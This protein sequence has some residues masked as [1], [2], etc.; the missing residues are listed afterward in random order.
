M[1][2]SMTGYAAVTRDLPLGTLNLELR[3]V[4]HR[5]L[6]VS[7][8]APEE[9][10]AFEPAMREQLGAKLT[11]GKLECRIGFNRAPTA[12]SVLE[13]NAAM[14]ARL[15]QLN[16]QVRHSLPD[17]ASLSVADVLR[18]PGMFG[19]DTLPLDELREACLSLLRQ[20]L[21]EFTASRGR[22]G[23]KLKDLILERVAKMEVLAKDIAPRIPQ[24]VVAQQEKFAQRLRDAGVTMDEERVRQEVVVFASR[25]DVEEELGRLATHV[26]EVRRIL[27]KGGATGKRLDFLMQELNREA[28][29]LGSKSTD[30]TVS[31]TS[32]DLKVL[33][34]QI[35]EQVQNIE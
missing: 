16:S 1:I 23:E 5:Y 10:R 17:A 18:W 20:A 11:R 28:N 7:F 25:I 32:M 26:S 2:Y 14:F 21:D 24:L 12:P 27:D 30:T 13:L 29:T 35:R 3:S 22:E 9:F 19:A 34:E 15:V 33:I 4:N 8:R 6:D 31:Q